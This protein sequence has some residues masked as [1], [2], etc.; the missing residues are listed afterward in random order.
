MHYFTSKTKLIYWT[1]QQKK[2]VLILLYSLLK[3]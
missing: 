1:F 3:R 2:S